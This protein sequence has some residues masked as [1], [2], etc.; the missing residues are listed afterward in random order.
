MGRSDDV[1]AWTDPGSCFAAEFC[2]A[3][4]KAM[5]ILHEPDKAALRAYL[6]KGG[7]GKRKFTRAQVANLPDSYWRSHCRY[8]IPCSEVLVQRVQKVLAD[9]EGAVCA[10]S[11]NL[12]ITEEVLKVHEL[13][14]KLM[15]EGLH[16]GEHNLSSISVVSCLNLVTVISFSVV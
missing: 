6:L 2:R 3:Y 1:H 7:P 13:Q 4:S 8:T 11:S 5:F 12:L 14:I 9:F 16:S 15:E 10:K